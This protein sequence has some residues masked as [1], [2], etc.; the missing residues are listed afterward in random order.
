[1]DWKRGAHASTFGGNPVAIAA[2]MTTIELLQN[3]LVRNS[4]DVGAYLKR[5][6][7]KLA[8]ETDRIGD[9]RGMGLMI[10]V[11]FVKDRASKKPDPELRDR[12]ELASFN[13]GLILLGCGE[14]SIRWS[15]PLVLTRENVD[16]ALELFADAIRASL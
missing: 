12:V 15:P 3:E 11:E 13:R 2:A 8:G 9:V 16:V 14:N 6:L 10:G 1:M 7:E 5:G 4:A